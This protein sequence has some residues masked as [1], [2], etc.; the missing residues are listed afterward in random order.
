LRSRM[1]MRASLYLPIGAM[2]APKQGIDPRHPPYAG[3]F[4]ASGGMAIP[5][6]KLDVEERQ[7][8]PCSWAL[9]WC[10]SRS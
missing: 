8:L 5:V 1:S 10:N 9:K 4:T 3:T 2:G 7:L 6:E